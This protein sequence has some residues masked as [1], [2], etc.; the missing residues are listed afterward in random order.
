MV[1]KHFRNLIHPDWPASQEQPLGVAESK[2]LRKQFYKV[3]ELIGSCI[4]PPEFLSLD[5]YLNLYTLLR[6]LHLTRLVP[7]LSLCRRTILP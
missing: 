1:R 3:D 6:S 7:S 2:R 5:L 4:S